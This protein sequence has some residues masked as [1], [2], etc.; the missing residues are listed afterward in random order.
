MV[1]GIAWGALEGL[2]M[3]GSLLEVET[4][5]ASG[6][7]QGDQAGDEGSRGTGASLEGSMRVGSL[8]P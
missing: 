8:M 3:E 6:D 7:D 1:Y 2:S 5:G 4:L